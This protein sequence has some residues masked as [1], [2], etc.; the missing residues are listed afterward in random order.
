MFSRHRSGDE[1]QS[2]PL[3]GCG[4][5]TRYDTF[6]AKMSEPAAENGSRVYGAG[7]PQRYNPKIGVWS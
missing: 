6:D 2:P 1:K 4:I 5:Q 7:E 3:A